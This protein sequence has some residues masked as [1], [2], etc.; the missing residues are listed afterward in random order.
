MNFLDDRLPPRFWSKCVPEPNSG[1]WL[2]CVDTYHK[3]GYAKFSVNNKMMYAHRVA[4]SASGVTIGA[5]QVV[6]HL[7]RT[8][9]CVNPLHLEAVSLGENQR[10]GDQGRIRGSVGH[11]SRRKS[12]CPHGHAYELHGA[13]NRAGARF[14]RECRRVECVAYRAKKKEGK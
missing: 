4:L 9:C 6:D 10:R 3:L 14:C 13:L 12:S 8:P 7:C 2:W 1:C 5:R 11:P